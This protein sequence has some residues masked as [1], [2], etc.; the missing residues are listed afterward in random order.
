MS[1]RTHH[2]HVAPKAPGTHACS[3]LPTLGWGQGE[4]G[5]RGEVMPS[6]GWG[7]REI[8]EFKRFL[9]KQGTSEIRFF[10]QT[11]LE[12]AET[13][14]S[15]SGEQGQRAQGGAGSRPSQADQRVQCEHAAIVW[16]SDPEGPQEPWDTPSASP[17]GELHRPGCL[18]PPH[19]RP[20]WAQMALA[21]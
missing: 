15:R 17:H 10:F 14:A 9:W 13:I 6:F 18:W 4:A 5:I 2:P 20:K 16:R 3:F 1:W 11:A 21:V 19:H 12:T 8:R 7:S